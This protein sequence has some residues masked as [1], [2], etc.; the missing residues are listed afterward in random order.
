MAVRSETSQEVVV[1]SFQST[2]YFKFFFMHR[3]MVPT[4]N[5]VAQSPPSSLEFLA[6]LIAVV[7]ASHLCR[8]PDA[9]GAGPSS[10]LLHLT[11]S[12]SLLVPRCSR[13]ILS[14]R[15]RAGARGQGGSNLVPSDNL[16]T[17]N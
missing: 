16:M 5:L 17:K 11:A 15:I 10:G 4:A 2:R 13:S 9:Y 6:L 8:H 3:T 12:G 1:P 7:E 14:L